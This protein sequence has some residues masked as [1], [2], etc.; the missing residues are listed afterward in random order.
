MTDLEELALRRDKR[1]LF[2]VIVGVLLGIVFGIFVAD[3]L[4]SAGTG[5]C[6][7]RSFSTFDTQGE[8]TRPQ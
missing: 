4:T 8:G 2:R 5:S 1:F 6:A 7:A 3:R